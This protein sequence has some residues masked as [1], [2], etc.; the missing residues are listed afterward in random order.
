MLREVP[1]LGQ[2]KIEVNIPIPKDLKIDARAAL[3]IRQN[4]TAIVFT[5]AQQLEALQEQLNTLNYK[6]AILDQMIED[7]GLGAEN[8]A[9]AKARVDEQL[10]AAVVV[11]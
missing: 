6:L 5:Q 11:S 2:V 4:I 10:A 8:V 3:W 7:H 9:A 1:R